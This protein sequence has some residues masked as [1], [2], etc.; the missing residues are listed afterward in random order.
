MLKFEQVVIHATACLTLIF[1]F[2]FTVYSRSVDVAHHFLLIDFLMK[3]DVS[4]LATSPPLAAVA[5]YP[6]GAHWLAA[7]LAFLTGS[8]YM[9]MWLLSIAAI[10]ICY[11]AMCRM[12]I[13]VGGYACLAVFV[14][15]IAAA[16]WTKAITGFEVR[17]N[18]FY[19]QLIGTAFYFASLLTISRLPVG[20]GQIS[21]V[22]IASFVLLAVHLL[23]ALN[24]IGT[25]A[26]LLV[27][28]VLLQFS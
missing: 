28:N 27:L 22:L 20:P 14:V 12:I 7:G 18:F 16:Y 13:E 24:L 4:N 1:F 5:H 8:P 26:I 11:Y 15:L 10:Y 25:M 21:Y 6:R 3:D 23:P 17:G 9:S 2:G 19:A